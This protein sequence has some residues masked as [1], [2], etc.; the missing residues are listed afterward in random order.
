MQ[1]IRFLLF[2]YGMLNIIIAMVVREVFAWLNKK[3][4]KYFDELP[5]LICLVVFILPPEWL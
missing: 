2:Q 3:I 4:K 5:Q 1:G